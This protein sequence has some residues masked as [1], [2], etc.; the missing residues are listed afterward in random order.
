MIRAT[1]RTI[2][3]LS[4]QPTFD[5]YNEVVGTVFGKKPGPENPIDNHSHGFSVGGM[6]VYGDSMRLGNIISDFLI[7]KKLKEISNIEVELVTN[8]FTIPRI[9]GHST[10]H[11]EAQLAE[12]VTISRIPVL[13]KPDG[14]EMKGIEKVR[15]NIFLRDFRKKIASRVKGIQDVQLVVDEIQKEFERYRNE[16]LIEKHKDAC[17]ME[18]CA[19]NAV[20]FAIGTLIPGASEAISFIEDSETRTMNWTGFIASLEAETMTN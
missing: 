16:L 8:R 9:F 5:R 4:S 6:H 14:P 2:V 7:A 19:R 13:Q 1:F 12:G 3:N 10:I 18:S 15:K 20:S 11:R 17:L